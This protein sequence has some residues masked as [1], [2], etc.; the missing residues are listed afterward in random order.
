MF[1]LRP[2][3]FALIEL[4]LVLVVI[5]LIIGGI[6][7]GHD[8]IEAAKV[9]ATI[10]Q[11]ERFNAATNAFT[12][13][14]NSIPGDMPASVAN[15]YGFAVRSGTTA[16]GDGNGLIEGCWYFMSQMY[17]CENAL[18]WEDLGDAQ[19][20]TGNYDAV[21]GSTGNPHNVPAGQRRFF[22]HS[23]GK[24]GCG[25]LFCRLYGRTRKL[26]GLSSGRR[27]RT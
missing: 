20:I 19:L 24:I 23:G 21:G 6:L 12:A 4:S 13:K 27:R 17:G 7:V 9:R 25:Q 11:I 1:R 15:R 5:G 8:L 10:S 22:I 18:F 14:Y 26:R 16:D 3:G 2:S